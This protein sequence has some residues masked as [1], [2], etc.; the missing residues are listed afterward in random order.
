MSRLVLALLLLLT[1]PALAAPPESPAVDADARRLVTIATSNQITF[2][3]DGNEW[4]PVCRCGPKPYLHEIAVWMRRAVVSIEDRR[5]F[6]HRGI[7][8][9]GIVRAVGRRVMRRSREGGSTLTQQLVKNTVL[10]ARRTLG[11]KR[12]EIRIAPKL[13]GAMKKADILRAYLNQVVFGHTRG[14]PVVG[15]EQAARHFFGRRAQDLNLYESAVL[16]GMLKAPSTY[17]PIRRP[18]RARARARLVL[19]AMV[20][21]EHIT[22]ADMAFALSKAGS[23][24]RG[25]HAPAWAETRNFT[26]WALAAVRRDVDGFKPGPSTRIVV[27]LEMQTQA[28]AQAALFK[29]TPNT[30]RLGGEY[31]YVAMSHGGRVIAM[32]GQ[33]DFG[34]RPFNFAVRARRQPASTFKPFVYL[35]GL[36]AGL[37]RDGWAEA[38]ARS[39]NDVPRAIANAVGPATVAETARR[40]GIASPLRADRSLALGTSEVGLLEITGAYAAIANGGEKIEPF[41]YRGVV[42]DGRL[43]VWRGAKRERVARKEDVAA[44]DAMLA[45]VVREGT[46][47]GAVRREGVRGKTGTSDGNRDAWFVGYDERRVEGLWLGHPEGGSLGSIEGRDAASVWARVDKALPRR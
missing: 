36:E 15:V 45:A 34:R 2:R 9:I 18:E 19:A 27:T 42:Q 20:R 47:L 26:Q 14:R 40:L 33:R 23:R 21:D 6:Q 31:G 44:L 4:R 8:P 24:K 28:A 7:D 30:R 11:R 25:P 22:K 43:L 38:M 32:V 37:A 10:D 5:F 46:A 16:A 39:D 41:G 1:A 13:E 12:A 35:A 17:H 3:R 29:A